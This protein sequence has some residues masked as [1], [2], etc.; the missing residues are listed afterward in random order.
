MHLRQAEEIMKKTT[1]LKMAAVFL[2]TTAI[3]HAQYPNQPIRII[4]PL[5]VYP[6]S[7]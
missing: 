3:A 2:S 5:Y 6:C 1:L 7:D 4:A